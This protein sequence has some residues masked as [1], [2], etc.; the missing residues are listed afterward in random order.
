[1]YK[2][3]YSFLLLLISMGAHAQGIVF[4]HGT[5]EEIKTKARTSRKPI[6]IDAYT[7][8]CKPCKVMAATV[9]TKDSVGAYFNNTFINY[10]MDME[11]GEGIAFAKKYEVNAFPTLLYFDAGGNM[12]YKAV[13]SKTAEGLLEQAK[14]SMDPA[15]QL[16]TYRDQYESGAKTLN[17]L[18]SYISKLRDAGSY[19]TATEAIV[20][21]FS[22]LKDTVKYSGEAWKIISGFVYRYDSDLFVMVLK[23]RQH[24]EKVSDRKEVDRYIFNVLTQPRL[25]IGGTRGNV[26]DSKAELARYINTL[27]QYSPYI[28]TGYFIGRMQYLAYLNEPDS[29]YFYA[30]RFLDNPGEPFY[31][32]DKFAYFNAYMANRYMN[33][34]GEKRQAALRWALR[35]Q[36]LAPS[37]Y[38][39]PYVLAQIHY[40]QGDLFN[41]LACAE[42]ALVLFKQAS[43]APVITQLFR[44]DTIAQFVD[45]VKQKM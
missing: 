23:N 36:R 45:E 12:T 19:A 40:K 44:G 6:F 26:N 20:T 1:M 33:E 10:K 39:A 38:K 2:K 13:G 16:Q 37:D 42:K 11:K 8:W 4:E 24:Y 14:L 22:F 5:W 25:I 31:P 27:H 34:A 32:D 17:D 15:F 29:A 18:Y 9:F 28:E 43:E 7:S 3:I 21:H 30:V 41:A 35:A